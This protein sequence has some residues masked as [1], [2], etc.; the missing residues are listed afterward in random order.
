MDSAVAGAP[1]PGL[2]AWR[3][4]LGGFQSLLFLAYP[5]IVYFA[6]RRFET[7]VAAGLLL[8][9]I[10]LSLALRIRGPAAEVWQLVRQHLGLVLLIGLAVVTG[11]RVVLLLLPTAVG[12]FL[13]GTF[14][15][16]LRAG[17]PIIERFARLVDPDLP[18]FCVPYCRKVTIVWCGFMAAN[19]AC[20]T[21]L[22][23]VGP[24]EWWALYTGLVAYL[25]L[26]ALFAAEFIV[27]KLWFRFYGDGLA[28]RV[29][30][31]FFPA[32]RTANGRRSLAYVQRRLERAAIR[33]SA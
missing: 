26:G 24:L 18:D 19:A 10:V 3:I 33:P 23:V 7:R 32:E 15:W 29:L 20:A 27:R 8:G 14:G 17:P 22:A 30:A 1:H 25:L 6:H 28:D 2:P 4:A 31:R 16:S 13:L 9:L 11:Q 21:L 5:F 12:L